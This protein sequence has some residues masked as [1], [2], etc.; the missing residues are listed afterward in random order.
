[1]KSK[2]KIVGMVPA[3]LGSKR[4]KNKNL[5]L[6]GKRPLIQYI[7]DSAVKSKMLDEIYI[8]SESTIFENIAKQNNIKFYKRAKHLSSDTATNDDFAMDFIDNI[9]CDLLIQ[10][11]PTSPFLSTD[12]IDDFINQIII[13]NYDTL[14]SV[15]DVRI[16]CVYKNNAINFDS[17]KQTPP[18]QLLEPIKSYACGIMGW[19]TDVFRKNVEKYNAAYHGGDGNTGFFNLKGFSTVDVDTEEDFQLAEAILKSQKIV[20]PNPKYYNSDN[21]TN[22]YDANVANILSGDGV[23]NNNQDSFNLE[24]LNIQKLIDKYGKDKSWSHTV[25]NSPSNS[26]TLIAQLP[27]E[28]NRMHYHHDWDEWWYIIEGKWEWY[29]DGSVREINEGE[30]VFIE[31]NRKHKITAAGES[32]AIRLAV[33]RYDVDHVYTEEDY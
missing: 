5:R 8:N 12:E 11:L 17:K 28:G 26:A 23:S 16:E 24:R 25:I 15:S 19:K 2:L 9:E 1:M 14:I 27:G 6:I 3:R 10:L 4:V 13:E 32:M 7:I 33:S 22:I 29:I 21:K 30:V 31:R 20:V 18:S